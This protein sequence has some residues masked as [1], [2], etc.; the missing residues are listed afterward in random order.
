MTD[1]KECKRLKNLIRQAVATTRLEA[2]WVLDQMNAA[3]APDWDTAKKHVED[4]ERAI[5]RKLTG[6][7]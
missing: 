5:H 2:T 4:A 6:E 1:C 7:G 3:E